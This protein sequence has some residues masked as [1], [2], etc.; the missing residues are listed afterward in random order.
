MVIRFTKKVGS[1]LNL[2][3]IVIYKSCVKKVMY[4]PSD[5]DREQGQTL[6][7]ATVALASILLTLAAISVAISTSVSNSQFVKQQ[8]QASK[9][10]QDG[11]EQLRYER[12]TNTTTFFARNG[13]YCM[14]QDNNLVTG[15]CVTANLSNTFKREVAFTQSSSVECG[16]TTKVVVSVYWATGKCSSANT[17][18]HKSQLV[19]CFSDQTGT[20]N[21]L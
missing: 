1:R 9:F 3:A 6:V 14:N 13:I 11:M 16:N 7:E 18:C 4:K 10:A 17:F 20:S 5:Q 19:S 8:S 21:T 15:A 12:N 2:G